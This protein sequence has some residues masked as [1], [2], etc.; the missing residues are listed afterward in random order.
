M[1]P[2]VSRAVLGGLYNILR[3]QDHR[4]TLCYVILPL[5]SEFL[6]LYFYVLS[7]PS[8]AEEYYHIPWV[9]LGSIDLLRFILNKY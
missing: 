6:E 5:F 3:N 2:G 9:I 4:T 8:K 1:Y 7:N